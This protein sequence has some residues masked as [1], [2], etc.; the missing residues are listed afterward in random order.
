LE[1]IG[2]LLEHL[3]RI[4]EYFKMLL[5]DWKKVSVKEISNKDYME[6]TDRLRRERI[7]I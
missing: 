6:E 2:V 4:E 1:T 5:D 7:K 3:N